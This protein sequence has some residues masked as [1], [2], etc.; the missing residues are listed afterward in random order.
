MC[1]ME[2]SLVMQQIR[3]MKAIDLKLHMKPPKEGSGRRSKLRRN[4]QQQ[5]ALGVEGRAEPRTQQRAYN[6]G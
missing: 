2:K 1:Y 3:W 6:S 5:F 4:L